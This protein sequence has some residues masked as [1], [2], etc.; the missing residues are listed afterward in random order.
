M[1]GIGIRVMIRSFYCRRNLRT[2]LNNY[3]IIFIKKFGSAVPFV[4]FY[5]MTR[6]E[7]NLIDYRIIH[8]GES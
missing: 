6:M 1:F 3:S 8:P 5:L 4:M 7:E 2:I